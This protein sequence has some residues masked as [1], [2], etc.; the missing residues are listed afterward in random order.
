MDIGLLVDECWAHAQT[1]G[2][3]GRKRNIKHAHQPPRADHNCNG[4]HAL[5][6]FTPDPTT[7][8]TAKRVRKAVTQVDGTTAPAIRTAE[9]IYASQMLVQDHAAERAAKKTKSASQPTAST[10]STSQPTT[11]T[12]LNI[13]T[14]AKRY[15]WQNVNAQPLLIMFMLEQK[16][17][18]LAV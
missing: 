15:V 6:V 2:F 18:L 11:S 3:C 7:T 16:R 4:N 9:A 14:P 8:S 12:S 10:S 5:V 1:Q 17:R 13:D